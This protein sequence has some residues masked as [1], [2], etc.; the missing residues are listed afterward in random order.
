M[1]D[2]FF[3]SRKK[4]K[5]ISGGKIISVRKKINLYLIIIFMISSIIISS[6]SEI[7]KNDLDESK[8]SYITLKIGKGNNKVYV[9]SF[10]YNNPPIIIYI[11]ENKQAIVEKSYQ[12][13]EPDNSVILIWEKGINNSESMFKMCNKIIEMD[14]THFDTSQVTTMKDMFYNCNNLKYINISNIDTSKVESMGNMFRGCRSLISIDLSSLNTSNNINIGSMFLGCSLLKSINL[15]NFNTSKVNFMDNLFNGCR[16]LIS[17]DQSNFDTSQVT[18][19]N[20]MFKDCKSLISINISSFDTNNV[21]KFQNMFYG[22]TSLIS[23]DFQN[24]DLSSDV[25]FD[26]MFSNCKNLKYVNIKNFRLK[27]NNITKFFNDCP[28]N[29][30]ICMDNETLID[31]IKSNDCNTFSCS[32]NWYE[33]RKKITENGN[34]IENC[35][36]T[37]SKYYY[38]LKCYS[39]CPKGTYNNDYICENCHEDCELCNGPYTVNNSNCISC[40]LKNKYLY[41]GNCIDACPKNSSY[42]NIT[43]NQTICKCELIECNTCSIES[44][45]NN[46]CT[47]CNSEE[48]YYPI[49][50]D[51][52]VNNLPFY[53]CY[54]SLEGYYFDIETSSFKLC[55]ISIK[56]CVKEGN[57]TDNN[58]SE[59]DSNNR[60]YFDSVEN[61]SYYHYFDENA[62][63]SYCTNNSTCPINYSKLIVDKKECI[64]NCENDTR[65]KYEFRSKCY[66]ECPSSSI[67][68]QINDDLSYL[69]LNK[70]YF[71]KPIC[72]EDNPFEIIYIQK[73][74]EKCDYKEIKNKSC[75]LNYNNYIIKDNIKLKKFIM[76]Y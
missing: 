60:S 25:N 54:K 26:N 18:E 49:Y 59:N 71:C 12:F 74:I 64:F 38:D 22:C 34:C 50:D 52:Y 36:L 46:S 51:L 27:N 6:I 42:L 66:S 55:N 24:F 47:S 1:E 65:Y 5:I 14:L 33:L 8:Y 23:L 76:I 43:I 68:R 40:S 75:I 73:C 67:K 11:N 4:N 32:D 48:G 53:K 35:S 45:N 20:N 13:E 28:I 70:I 19:M 41:L 62:N 9:Y 29:I 37:S 15:S 58:S 61:C 7:D 10:Y 16:S 39:N 56:T 72:N 31:T 30:V 44:L 3:L 17:V 63:I 21:K 2:K 57:K 69:S